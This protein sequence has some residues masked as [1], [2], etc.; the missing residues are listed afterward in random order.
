MSG[1]LVFR[2][3]RPAPRRTSVGV[4]PLVF[5]GWV[6]GIAFAALALTAGLG[7]LAAFLGYALGGA[8]ITV[9]AGACALM[10]DAQG[11]RLLVPALAR[12][13]RR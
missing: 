12:A 10:A 2:F 4:L 9:A 3:R 5:A 13:R 11:S 6:G 8:A 7:W 1:T